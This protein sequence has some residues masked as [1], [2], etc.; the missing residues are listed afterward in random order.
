MVEKNKL[1]LLIIFTIFIII[2]SSMAGVYFIRNIQGIN[3]TIK[4]SDARGLYRGSPLEYKGIQIGSVQKIQNDGQS[5]ISVL[6]KIDSD[7]AEDLRQNALFVIS[8]DLSTGDPPGILMGYC[9]DHDLQEFPKMLSGA[10]IT[11]EDSELIFLLKTHVGCFSKTSGSISDTLESLKK[12]IDR[13]LNSPKAQQLYRDI[14]T[15]FMDLS[16]MTQEHFK[17]FMEEKGPEIRNKIEEFIKEL[18]RMGH[19]KEAEDWKKFMEEVSFN[20]VNT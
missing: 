2:G 20:P 17:R 8:R 6:V 10:L 7:A 14:E 5:K 4:F 1:R 3:L 19:K 15:F 11:G 12:N 16:K 9:R 13:L 18:E